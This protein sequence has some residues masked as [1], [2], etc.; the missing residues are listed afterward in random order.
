MEGVSLYLTVLIYR[1]YRLF[2]LIVKVKPAE[3]WLFYGPIATA[4]IPSVILAIVLHIFPGQ[5]STASP[6]L[7]ADGYLCVTLNPFYLYSQFTVMLCQGL[8]CLVFTVLTD[9]ISIIELLEFE[10]HLTNS[11]KISLPYLFR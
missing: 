9:S 11:E 8:F 6:I 7:T 3:G 4:Y 1:L 10:L 2:F 5:L